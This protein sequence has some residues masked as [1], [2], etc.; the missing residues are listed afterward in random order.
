MIRNAA[1]AG[2]FYP[3]WAGELKEMISSMTDRAAEKA[4]VIGI[5]SPLFSRASNSAARLS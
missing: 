3:G 5:V 4:E 1:V 2:Q